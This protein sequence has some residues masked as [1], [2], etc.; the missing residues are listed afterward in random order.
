MKK[1]LIKNYKN[2]CLIVSLTL[3]AALFNVVSVLGLIPIVDFITDPELNTDNK[4]TIEL[5]KIY[6]YLGIS[7]SLLSFGLFY[8]ILILIKALLLIIEKYTASKIIM[9]I[10]KNLIFEQYKS[11]LDASYSFFQNKEYGKLSNTMA[12]ETEKAVTGL[13]ALSQFLASFLSLCLY[14][15]L[16]ILLSWELTFIVLFISLIT[17]LPISYFLNVYVYRIRSEHTDASN[18]F[19]GKIYDTLNSIKLILGFSKKD[20]VFNEVKP[21][22][23]SVT[24]TAVKFTMS[25]VVLQPITEILVVVLIIISVIYGLEV[26]KIDIPTLVA[27]LYSIQRLG[28]EAQAVMNSRNGITASLP[29]FNQIDS[30]SDEAIS[31]QERKG[32]NPIDSL[33]DSIKIKNLEF[34]YNPK[35]KILDGISIEIP[36]GS[37]IGIVGP[38]GSGKSSLIDLLLGF[39]KP[40]KG[41]IIID[42][43]KLN[44]IEISS[45]RELIGYIPQQPFL[46]NMSIKDNMLWSN[47]NASD[48]E[49]YNACKLANAHEFIISL[50]DGYNTIVG[51]RGAKLSGGQAQR[52]CLARALVKKPDILILD[53]ATSSLDSNSEKLIQKSIEILSGKITI[54]SIAH[55]LSTI[56]SADNIFYL[57]SG[58]IIESGNFEQLMKN[59]NGDFYKSATDQG[60]IHRNH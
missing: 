46:F 21:S 6:T 1:V 50:E 8:F 24:K 29:S 13:E 28:T 3:L 35:V 26:S 55:R 51:E 18:R 32:G 48:E 33:R 53:E 12:K 44:N 52:I 43:V 4:I 60:I 7:P 5:I 59:K 37:M 57:K 15:I 39:N 47:N 45:W 34:G 42:D 22:V 36:Q 17:L 30:L 27:F 20:K 58:K 11:F 19:Q 25:R 16:L 40:D 10:M 9:R 38:S 2:I 23:V 54:I 31:F 56:K 49:I 14:F 41:E